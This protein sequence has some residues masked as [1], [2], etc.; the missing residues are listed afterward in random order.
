MHNDTELKT[1]ETV[2][3]AVTKSHKV[4]LVCKVDETDSATEASNALREFF[5]TVSR[6]GKN[7][8]AGSSRSASLRH[9]H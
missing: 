4:P 2:I 7:M 6:I 5:N 1:D 8:A 3:V 9:H